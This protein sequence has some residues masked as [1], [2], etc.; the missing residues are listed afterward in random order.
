MDKRRTRRKK[1]Q[2][3]PKR[4]DHLMATSPVA[5]D[6]DE[7]IVDEQPIASM[8]SEVWNVSIPKKSRSR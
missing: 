2:A 6:V 4:N 7:E 1:N 8:S 3:T 5:S